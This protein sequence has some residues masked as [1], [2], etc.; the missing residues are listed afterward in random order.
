M[1]AELTLLFKQFWG[2]EA[3]ISWATIP[4][5]QPTGLSASRTAESGGRWP[6]SRPTSSGLSTW[7]T[8]RRRGASSTSSPPCRPSTPMG[9]RCTTAWSPFWTR[10]P[11]T[12]SPSTRTRP[13]SLRTTSST[14][15]SCSKLV[16]QY[17]LVQSNT[18]L[19]H[20]VVAQYYLVQF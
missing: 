1:P 15:Q 20:S 12:S 6:P 14:G 2:Q 16:A 8:S 17:C 11:R 19:F 18:I 13:P 9:A 5:P 7:S 4:P 10:G 3:T